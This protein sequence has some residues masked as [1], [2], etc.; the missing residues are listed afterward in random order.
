MPDVIQQ[1][2]APT[3]VLC[4][5]G[6][7]KRTLSPEIEVWADTLAG[8]ARQQAGE[9]IDALVW[10]YR[11]GVV[12]HLSVDLRGNDGALSLTFITG[13][14]HNFGVDDVDVPDMTEALA[15]AMFLLKKINARVTFYI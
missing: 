8:H 2:S 1:T 9:R 12:E 6:P 13:L 10:P 3:E 11:H 4:E 7:C 15:M 14:T 5:I